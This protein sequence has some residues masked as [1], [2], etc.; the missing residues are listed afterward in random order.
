MVKYIIF[1][2][3]TLCPAFMLNA[4]ADILQFTMTPTEYGYQLHADSEEI[5]QLV[6]ANNHFSFCGEKTCPLTATAHYNSDGSFR[7]ITFTHV[8]HNK[9]EARIDL[10]TL[11][12]ELK[13]PCYWNGRL[14]YWNWISINVAKRRLNFWC[15]THTIKHSETDIATLYQPFFSFSGKWEITILDPSPFTNF[16]GTDLDNTTL[17]CPHSLALYAWILDN[18]STHPLG[19]KYLDNDF[20]DHVTELLQSLEV[21]RSTVSGTP[22][23]D[24]EQYQRACETLED[25]LRSLDI[26]GLVLSENRVLFALDS[27]FP[28][29]Y[30]TNYSEEERYMMSLVLQDKLLGS[31]KP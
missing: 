30:D 18:T 17:F 21:F 12:S 4:E 13:K 11:H 16:M 31:Q 6:I 29:L 9:I 10:F 7:D 1:F 15:T 14:S 19:W 8:S 27:C 28:L 22:S 3:A 25:H 5:A 2:L 20:S 23:L 24:E 26:D